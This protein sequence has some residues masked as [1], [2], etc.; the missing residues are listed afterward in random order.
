VSR[1]PLV[2]AQVWAKDATIVAVKPHAAFRP[3]F[4]AVSDARR[5]TPKAAPKGG[6]TIARATG[7]EP[8]IGTASR[9]G[10]AGAPRR[11][12]SFAPLASRLA[13]PRALRLA[14]SGLDGAASLCDSRRSDAA[15]QPPLVPRF[16]NEGNG[17]AQ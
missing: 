12:S 1:G 6:V 8:S 13:P 14:R 17:G 16:S 3:Y 2:F 5:K 11:R 7:V 10:A 15:A 9:S 4:T